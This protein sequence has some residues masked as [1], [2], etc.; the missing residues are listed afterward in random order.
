M[1]TSEVS[2][3]DLLTMCVIYGTSVNFINA[4]CIGNLEARDYFQDLSSV[5]VVNSIVVMFFLVTYSQGQ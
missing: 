2:I 1:S 5:T 3:Y 4:K